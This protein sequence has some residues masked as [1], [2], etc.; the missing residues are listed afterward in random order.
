MSRARRVLDAFGMGVLNQALTAVVG[1]AVTRYVL[2]RIG[3]HDY[4]LWIVAGQFF[5]YLSFVDLGVTALLPREVAF[6]TGKP[7]DEPTREAE[8]RELVSRSVTLVM[9]LIPPLVLGSFAIVLFLPADWSA[10]LRWP[11][12]INLAVFV[13]TYPMRIAQGMLSGL[14][15][16]GF[17]ARAQMVAWAIGTA[18]SV[19]LVHF[20]FGLYAVALGPSATQIFLA[21]AWAARLLA[22]HRRFLPRHIRRLDRELVR[23]HL[24][25]G[26]WVSA[27]MLAQV[28]VNS[29]DT[30]IIG[31][32]RGTDAVVQYSFTDKTQTLLNNQPY[33]L[34]HA[35]GPALSELRASNDRERLKRGMAALATVTLTASGACFIAIVVTNHAF[36][37]IW[38]GEEFFGGM[39]LTA[40]LVGNMLVRHW[41]FTYLQ[42]LFFLGRE[43]TVGI[44]ALCDGVLTVGLSILFVRAFG[45]LGAPLAQ[46]TSALI[47]HGPALLVLVSRELG[48]TIPE[49]LGLLRPWFV[50]FLPVAVLAAVAGRRLDAHSLPEVAIAGVVAGAI[51]GLSML[52][53]ARKPPLDAYAMPILRRIGLA[54]KEP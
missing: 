52:P 11:L 25:S 20:H 2:H 3:S 37:R 35:A 50:R 6:V 17:L 39:T 51:Y 41:L 49:L 43:R 16:M 47:T 30:L 18:V 24:A 28:L 34:A 46:L 26:G 14:Q 8:M 13:V 53:L 40:L 10:A 9:L 32:V 23:A 33:I 38:V 45:A 19:V 12:T 48:W 31:R 15:E 54:P 29:T 36:V 4:G 42:A 7:I 44:I 22:K 21:I 1:L 27:S 5:G